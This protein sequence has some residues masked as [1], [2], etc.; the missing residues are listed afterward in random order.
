MKHLCVFNDFGVLVLSL[1]PSITMLP[2]VIYML[3]FH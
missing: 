2:V 3:K 1:L